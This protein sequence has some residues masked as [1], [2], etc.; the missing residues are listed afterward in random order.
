[1]NN[2]KQILDKYLNYRNIWDRKDITGFNSTDEMGIDYKVTETGL[3]LPSPTL[4]IN[5]LF[6]DLIGNNFIKKDDV[7]LDAGAGDG[8]V[9]HIAVINGIESSI[10]IESDVDIVEK[11]KKQTDVLEENG[12]LKRGAVKLFDGNF[13]NPETYTKNNIDVSEVKVFFNY[14]NGW[15]ELI[16][17]IDKK[18]PINTKLVLINENFRTEDRVL[19]KISGYK[20]M[21][22]VQIVKYVY[23]K[24]KNKVELLTPKVLDELKSINP[25]IE[26][27]HAEIDM[28]DT[29]HASFINTEMDSVITVYLCEKILD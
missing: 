13:T 10:G 26:S 28:S 12:I 20:S 8:R 5:K 15:K 6:E 21:K 29:G 3:F 16:D 2:K 11:S 1:M 19:D 18:S 17:F 22:V 27:S 24:E 9:N 23:W 14:L 4:F 25:D 7:F